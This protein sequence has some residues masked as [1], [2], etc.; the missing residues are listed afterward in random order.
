MIRQTNGQTA[1]Q[2]VDQ[3][4]ACNHAKTKVVRFTQRNGVVIVR[5]QCQRCGA[6]VGNNLPKAEHNVAKLPEWN[7]SLRDEWWKARGERTSAV[8]EQQRADETTEWFRRYNVYLKSEQWQRLKKTVLQRDNYTCQNCFRK[9]APNLY[10]VDTRAEV[11]HTS[12]DGYNRLGESFAFE[13]VTLC[14]AC[15]RRY[16]GREKGADE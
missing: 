2:I 9:V 10:A 7:E 13:C 16:H 12:Y 11:H 15:H 4:F 8:Y 5:C 6:Q 3:E 1:Y 14:H